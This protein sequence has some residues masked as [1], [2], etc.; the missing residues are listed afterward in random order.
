MKILTGF[1]NINSS[2]VP[3][4]TIFDE[5]KHEILDFILE[6][7]SKEIMD[8][9]NKI[10]YFDK[11]CC[12]QDFNF[13]ILFYDCKVVSCHYNFVKEDVL[14]PNSDGHLLV[15]HLFIDYNECIDM[16]VRDP[17]KKDVLID[18]CD[19]FNEVS[20]T[21]SNI[22][23]IFKKEKF[24]ITKETQFG[25]YTIEKE[26]LKLHSITINDNWFF[27]DTR[28]PNMA[29]SIYDIEIH[30]EKMI[31]FRYKESKKISEIYQD[32]KK[33][34]LYF[35]FL[36]QSEIEILDISFMNT[37]KDEKD[38]YLRHLIGFAKV[39]YS[40]TF[41]P[42]TQISYKISPTMFD[43]EKVNVLEGL[44]IWF[45]RFNLLNDSLMI[46]DKTIYNSNKNLSDEIIWLC[47]SIEAL[48]N[49]VDEIYNSALQLIGPKQTYP[50]MGNYLKA[51]QDIYKLHSTL[52][53]TQFDE[54]IKIINKVRNKCIH[55]NP[56]L[57]TTE[58]ELI[59]TAEF[60]KYT[61]TATIF[62]IVGIINIDVNKIFNPS[63]DYKGMPV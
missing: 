45:E 54:T 29:M 60:L 61:Y 12:I 28:I 15:A 58:E 50:N 37:R 19:V 18:E 33:I 56:R 35:E 42:F 30:Q 10:K 23:K 47:Q 24:N 5:T 9:I 16:D 7:A 57:K 8:D 48:C 14:K 59:K 46:W 21:F 43:C 25:K 27:V 11:L 26:K 36:F 17:L 2:N 22:E 4:K 38:K 20:F 39:I 1:I 62:K 51:I 49:S 53:K 13:Y 3:F 55:N 44:K 6:N 31:N 34:K 40:K 63:V 41:I 32:I 52:D